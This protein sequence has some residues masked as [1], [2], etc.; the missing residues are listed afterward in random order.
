MVT[1]MTASFI[2]IAK[3]TYRKPI[4]IIVVS[5]K[6]YYGTWSSMDS[7][8]TR[9]VK[10]CYRRYIKEWIKYEISDHNFIRNLWRPRRVY[11]VSGL[12]LSSIYR[13][14]YRVQSTSKSI[15]CAGVILLHIICIF[16]VLLVIIQVRFLDSLSTNVVSCV[17]ITFT[18]THFSTCDSITEAAARRCT[19]PTG[20]R[21][22]HNFYEF[23]RTAW[24]VT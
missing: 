14:I 21:A 10:M 9:Y 15:S 12:Y 11:I 23:R 17:W 16:T 2:N 7:K 4:I 24:L 5:N 6:M 22:P 19:S 13:H 20:T 8:Q 3:L 18:S 1:K